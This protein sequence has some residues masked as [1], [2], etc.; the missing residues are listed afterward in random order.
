MGK[1]LKDL[2]L[3]VA[4]SSREV[5]KLGRPAT[6]PHLVDWDWETASNSTDIEGVEIQVHSQ[7]QSPDLRPHFLTHHGMGGRM[8][9]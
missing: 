5:K 8:S 4:T 1:E 2:M 3:S 7:I 9:A 6:A